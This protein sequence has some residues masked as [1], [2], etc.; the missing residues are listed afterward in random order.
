MQDSGLPENPCPV[1]G[2]LLGT[3]DQQEQ[4]YREAR[5]E[6]A[7][8]TWRAEENRRPEDERRTF[9]GSTRGEADKV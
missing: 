8:T 6:T 3:E 9:K 5:N 7:V 4:A 2:G 1:P